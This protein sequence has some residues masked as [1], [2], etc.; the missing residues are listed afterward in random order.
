MSKVNTSFLKRLIKEDF[1]NKDQDLISK[2]SSVFNPAIDQISRVLNKG[3]AV[4][5]LNTQTKTMT[6]ILNED[7]TPTTTTTFASTLSGKCS[8]VFVGRAQNLTNP[9]TY[10]TSGVFITYNQSND[11]ITNS[12]QVIINHVTGLTAGDQWQLTLL[13]CV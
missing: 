12:N 13:A 9:T 6:I 5:D 8:M 1:N 10:P 2:L 7:G 11:T 4:N 3:L